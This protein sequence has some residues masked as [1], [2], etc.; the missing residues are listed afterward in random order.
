MEIRSTDQNIE[1]S[2]EDFYE[3]L[4]ADH[5]I[6]VY[7]DHKQKRYWILPAYS[8]INIYIEFETTTLRD[9]SKSKIQ[10]H[11]MINEILPIVRREKINKILSGKRS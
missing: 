11:D 9:V 8:L 10:V 5:N 6:N 3:C 4:T 2:L 1:V 7:C